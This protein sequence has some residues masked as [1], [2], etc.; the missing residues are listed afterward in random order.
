MCVKTFGYFATN[1]Q[2]LREKRDVHK[3]SENYIYICDKCFVKSMRKESFTG[4][5]KKKNW[6]IA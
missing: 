3:M 6:N 2:G 4:L 1:S 5:R